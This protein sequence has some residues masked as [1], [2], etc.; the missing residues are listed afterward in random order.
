MRL[1]YTAP[2]NHAIKSR[3]HIRMAVNYDISK[4][5]N[6][7]HVPS[8]LAGQAKRE[9]E[10]WQMCIEEDREGNTS[11]RA[12]SLVL[13]CHKIFHSCDGWQCLWQKNQTKTG[14]Q[15]CVFS[16]SLSVTRLSIKINQKQLK[17]PENN[18]TQWNCP[19]SFPARVHILIF[20]VLYPKSHALWTLSCAGYSQDGEWERVREGEIKR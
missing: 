6:T 4:S 5:K 15:S 11:K 12:L 19:A 20:K 7:Y 14:Q 1:E 9:K 16:L 13:F 17:S 2:V 10:T 8:W 18:V 3:K